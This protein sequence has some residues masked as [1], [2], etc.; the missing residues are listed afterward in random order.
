MMLAEGAWSFPIVLDPKDD[1]GNFRFCINFQRLNE[2]TKKDAYPLPNM[3]S[4]LDKLRNAKYISKLDLKSGFWQVAMDE[5]SKEKT[6]FRV[7]GKGFF[8]FKVMPFGL[9]N[10]PATFQRLM[11]KVLGPV[12]DP[13]CF[14]YLDDIIVI[15]DT[16]A[17]HLKVLSQVFDLLRKANLKLNLD[18]CCF[19]VPELKYLGY[20]V[21][22]YGLHPDPDKVN[23][24]L[25]FPVPHNVKGVRKFLGI[26]SWYRKFIPNYSTVVHPINN[27]LKKNQK[28]SWGY[29]CQMAFESLKQ[30]LVQAPILRC[31]D[32][33]RRFK[34]Q[35]DA[36]LV[37]IGAALLQEFEDGEAVVS[38]AS[39]SL[40]TAEQ[41]YSATERECLAVVFAVEHFRP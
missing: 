19:C 17:K 13:Y 25:Q 12:L 10:S 37:G 15:T 16:F 40:S 31:P 41:K 32:F 1:K 5:A 34:I 11:D 20:I 3:N 6:G 38:Y 33:S 4:I 14:V 23:S 21:N 27:L 18:K 24:V 36:S 30:L 7:P 2:V 26:T 8:Q 28:W 39:R 22:K 29:K 35:T 9:C